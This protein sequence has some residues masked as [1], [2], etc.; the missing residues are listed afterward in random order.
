M[1]CPFRPPPLHI[2]DVVYHVKA[3]NI[4]DFLNYSEAELQDVIEEA[5]EAMGW[6]SVSDP[7]NTNLV[8]VKFEYPK[9]GNQYF[10]RFSDFDTP[11][12][13][14]T[15]WAERSDCPQNQQP[16]LSDRT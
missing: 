9:I 8:T 5:F 2:Y 1:I 15:Q 12:D 10:G 6:N 13:V 11:E 16:E 7:D 3:L 4:P 14:K